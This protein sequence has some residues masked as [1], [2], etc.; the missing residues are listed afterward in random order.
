MQIVHRDLKPSNVFRCRDG[1]YK[2]FDFGIALLDDTRLTATHSLVGTPSYLSPE[3]ARGEPDL[4]VRSD[5]WSLGAVLYRALA[6]QPPFEGDSLFTIVRVATQ[7]VPPL[8][9]VAPAAPA[10]LAAVVDRALKREKAERWPSAADLESAL[11]SIDLGD[12]AARPVR[13]AR[14]APAPSSA[15]AGEPRIVDRTADAHG[16]PEPRVMAILLAE[17]V[18]D[19]TCLSAAPWSCPGRRSP[20]IRSGGPGEGVS[21]RLI[22]HARAAARGHT[23]EAAGP[24]AFKRA[25]RPPIA[26]LMSR[27]AA[28]PW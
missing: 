19:L 12:A 11:A 2:I 15:P 22:Q 9:R 1:P 21:S 10:S 23:L 14:A 28:G 18:H 17:G 25:D 26:R 24:Q 20:D 16:P 3:Q 6:G 5:I 4:D 27:H 13:S 8:M 7:D